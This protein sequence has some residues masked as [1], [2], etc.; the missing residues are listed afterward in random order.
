[1]KIHLITPESE[2]SRRLRRWRLIQF[3][4]LTMPL[5][6]A[7]TPP[8]VEIHHTDEIVEKVDLDRESD[9]VAITCNTPAANHVYGL[10]D[11]FRRRG[12]KV[13]LGGP[14]VTVLTAEAQAHADAVVVG[15]AEAVWPRLVADFRSG[16]WAS[17]YRGVP[18]DLRG[19]PHA[20]RDLIK[21]RA[22]GRGVI[23]AT[24]GCP[25]RCGYCSIA[26]MYGPGQRRRPVEEVAREVAG[27]PGRAVIFWDD[28]L[29]ADRLYALE[30]FKA[31]APY[32]K[33]W[34]TQ[35]T[36]QVAFDAELLAA[37]VD[38]G[39]KAFFIGLESISQASLDSQGK[40]FNMVGLYAQAVENLHRHGIAIQA[41]TMFG[42]DGDDPGSFDRT[43]R[44]YR[45]IGIDS[46]TVSIAVPMPGT[47]YFALLR[48]EGRL[49]TTNWD[50]YNGK[51]DAVFQPKQMSARDLEQGVAWFADQFYS[52][53]SIYE[54][55][56]RR[57][58][59]GLWWNLPRNIGYRLALLWRD[60]VDFE[61]ANPAEGLGYR[62]DIN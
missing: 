25:N 23:I 19:L 7:L 40:G 52:V 33:W 26:N 46:A 42:L 59:V 22:Y 20:R 44:Y 32:G 16:S 18:A 8:D 58:R 27:I 47:A 30:L 49:L 41:G 21:G 35:T 29:T 28:H 60:G 56:I 38:S 51:V 4:Q 48:R 31:I 50:R 55:L 15:E 13:V 2:P 39:C 53:G 6:A 45:E 1:M 57:S 10:A 11:E 62:A 34:T 3:P 61:P 43:L 54:R 12:R 5:L 24:R 37:A 36:L 17:V 9:L 14:H